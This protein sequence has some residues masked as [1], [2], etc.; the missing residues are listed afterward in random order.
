MATQSPAVKHH[1]WILFFATPVFIGV[2]FLL[3]LLLVSGS[4]AEAKKSFDDQKKELGSAPVKTQGEVKAVGEQVNALEGDR[5]VL[6]TK[7]Y[8][9]QLDAG[10]FAWPDSKH[11]AFNA[12]AKTGM[13]FGDKFNLTDRV[14]APPVLTETFSRSY[15][16]LGENLAPTRFAGRSYLSA[17]RSVTDWGTI[18]VDPEPF[19]LALEDYW[20]QR[21]LL[22]PIRKVNAAA[23][24]FEDVTPKDA[25]GAELKRNFR[26]RTWELDLEVEAKGNKQVLK[27]QLRNVTPR[28]QALGVNKAMKVKVWLKDV[29]ADAKEGD[30][31][32]PDMVYEI[33]GE[34]VPGKGALACPAQEITAFNVTRINRVVQVFDEATV[35]VR[36]VNTIELGMLDNRN[37][38]LALEMPK[39]IETD[40]AA[41]PEPAPADPMGGMPN[42]GGRGMPG[43]TGSGP[44]GTGTGDGGPS[45]PYGYGGSSSGSGKSGTVRSVLLGNKKRYVKR[46]DDVRRM[47]VALSVVIDNDYTNDLMVAFTNSPL[48]FQITQTQWARF[49]GT[50]PPISGE[51]SGGSGATTPGSPFNPFGGGGDDAPAAGA[52][53]GGPRGGRPGFTGQ[54]GPIGSPE[55]GG[56]GAGPGTPGGVLA[57]TSGGMLPGEANANLCEFALFGIVSLYEQLP[58]PEKKDDATGGTETKPMDMTDPKPMDKVDPAKPAPMPQQPDATKPDP[59]KQP[60]PTKKDPAPTTPEDPK[61]DD[62]KK[63]EPKKDDGKTPA[64]TQPNK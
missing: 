3:M 43:V 24:L 34:S 8:Q 13:K 19:W 61:K 25:K 56:T 18:Q 45:S 15:T 29:P 41:N 9:E 20:V 37:K 30:L 27:G 48:H 1:F 55:S 53:G 60:D 46:T 54:T 39:H 51:T 58:P 16:R 52:A 28:L 17:L 21:G 57:P 59:T 33:R 40:E 49:K 22:D 26:T 5:K 14:T 31:P 64:P 35:P 47:P 50:L 7:S 2:A 11:A 4:I 63:E 12:L 36:L 23:A 62:G 38:A 10:V 32:E 6:W 42:E 44:G